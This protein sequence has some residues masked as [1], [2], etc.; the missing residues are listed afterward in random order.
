VE[1]RQ[2]A[3]TGIDGNIYLFGGE[4][5]CCRRDTRRV[6]MFDPRTGH[7]RRRAPFP[8]TADEGYELRGVTTTPEGSFQM[9]DATRLWTYDPSLDTWTAGPAW[10]AGIERAVVGLPDGR[11]LAL[12]SSCATD[13]GGRMTSSPVIVDPTTGEW[14]DGPAPDVVLAEMTLLAPV[15]PAEAAILSAE[16]IEPIGCSYSDSTMLERPLVLTMDPTFARDEPAA[17]PS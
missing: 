14:L 15:G 5:T 16:V 7:Y 1:A 17:E 11:L 6:V 4:S 9:V 10:P 8:G 3:A 2:A 12:R 13:V